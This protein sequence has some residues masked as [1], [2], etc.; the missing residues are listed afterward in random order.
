MKINIKKINYRKL[1]Y[2][3]KFVAVFSVFIAFCL[4]LKISSSSS[5]IT[6]KTISNIPIHVELSKTTKESGLSVFGLDDITSEITVSGN[7]IVLGQL[8]KDNIQVYAQQS[9]GII[10]AAGNYSLE[11]KARK[12]GVLTDYN[13]ESNVSP[14]YIN[15]FVDRFKSKTFNISSNISYSTSPTYFSPVTLSESSVTISGPDSIV[16]NI[17]KVCVEKDISEPIKQT[18]NIKGLPLELYDNTKKKITS[19]YLTYSTNKV[20]ATISLLNKKSLPLKP[21]YINEPSIWPFKSAAIKVVPES[22][23]IAA[24]TNVAAELKQ[25]EL[26]ALDISKVNLANY[27]FE[28]PLRIPQECRNLSNTY[29]ANLKIDMS[30]IQSKK[31]NVNKINFINIP[32]GKQATSSTLSLKVEILGP[33]AE[34]KKISSDDI[35][36]QV[37]LSSKE[38]FTGTTELPAK[39]VFSS[40]QSSCW[41]YGSYNIN[42]EIK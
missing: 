38:G 13:F 9:E 5:E 32:K 33:A 14:K 11:L 12:M 37:D 16:S 4:W 2:N 20:D 28:M 42:A 17:A 22:V 7:R 21:V 8:S 29:Y 10:D 19:K 6:N 41:A 24:P 25:I 39:I 3:N 23:E 18:T 31:V 36:I 34:I 26:E 40:S 15:V 1:F 30:G 27:T 35:S